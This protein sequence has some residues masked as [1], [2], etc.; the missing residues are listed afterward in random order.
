MG[1]EER[2]VLRRD[3]C[4][5]EMGVEEGKGKC[6]GECCSRKEL[7]DCRGEWEIERIYT[8]TMRSEQRVGRAPRFL[9]GGGWGPS[10]GKS[11]MDLDFQFL[12][13]LRAD[14]Q[15]TQGRSSAR[16]DF[17]GFEAA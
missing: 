9:G 2:R 10:K 6:R 12:N 14:N 4:R 13:I 7:V 15:P 11:K 8:G 5:G 16:D 3:G 17:S 1:V